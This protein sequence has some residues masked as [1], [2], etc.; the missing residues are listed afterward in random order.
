VFRRSIYAVKDI[1]AGEVLTEE[2]VRIIRPGY[3]L[4]PKELPKILGKRVVRDVARGTPVS[5][6][7]IA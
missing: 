7:L 4:A 3:G 2:N 6:H 5:W 1:E